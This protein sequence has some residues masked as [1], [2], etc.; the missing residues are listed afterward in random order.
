MFR[1]RVRVHVAKWTRP[2]A[3]RALLGRFTN[4]SG[5]GRLLQGAGA[6]APV[7]SWMPSPP[8]VAA[9]TAPKAGLFVSHHNSPYQFSFIAAHSSCLLFS[10]A[11]LF[12]SIR[13]EHHLLPFTPIHRPS[14]TYL[15]T[16]LGL[17]LAAPYPES[18]N[19]QTLASSTSTRPRAETAGK[20]YLALPQ[21]TLR[22]TL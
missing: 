14:A 7:H 21:H 9:S 13:P 16:L 8:L 22:A 3:S 6:G 2:N 4:Y 17:Y 11:V 15:P 5:S 19:R 12:A 18:G 20:G 1:R 10:C